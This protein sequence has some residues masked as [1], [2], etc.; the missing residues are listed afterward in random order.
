MHPGIDLA[1][2]LVKISGHDTEGKGPG[3]VQSG[4]SQLQ[5]H[6][7]FIESSPAF[8]VRTPLSSAP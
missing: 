2:D 4:R 8:R 5:A 7:Q 3:G 6:P 1:D